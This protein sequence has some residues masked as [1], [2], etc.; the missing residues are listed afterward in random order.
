MKL[1]SVE[2]VKVLT[3]ELTAHEALVLRTVS[4]FIGGPVD[5]NRRIVTELNDLLFEAGI[6]YDDKLVDRSP[7]YYKGIIL[8]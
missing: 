2:K 4:Q 5:G 8:K 6:G 3:L 1:S 7:Q